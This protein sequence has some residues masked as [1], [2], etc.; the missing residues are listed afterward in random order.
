MKKEKIIKA[1]KKNIKIESIII[2]Y[3][4]NGLV[5][6]EIAKKYNI[7]SNYVYKILHERNIDIVRKTTIIYKKI[8][9]DY[10]NGLEVEELAQKYSV[11]PAS[12]YRA[13]KLN[14]IKLRPKK[15]ELTAHQKAVLNRILNG[16][17]Q[18]SV[19]KDLGLSRQRV[20]QI[21]KEY[22]RSL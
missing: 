13:L 6:S 5:I 17:T 18:A 2:D 9:E 15:R 1:A 16:E 8:A 12:V 22:M 19:A 4:E 3:L 21:Y 14:S 11:C 10:I 7:S 20:N